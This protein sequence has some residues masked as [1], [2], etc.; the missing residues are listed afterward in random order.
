M[1]PNIVR[2]RDKICE[3]TVINKKAERKNNYGQKK[4]ISVILTFVVASWQRASGW[5]PPPS[6]PSHLAPS[7][8]PNAV[9]RKSEQ[10]WV[11]YGNVSE[12]RCMMGMEI[13]VWRLVELDAR[14]IME[15][16]KSGV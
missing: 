4:Q 5:M 12:A 3:Y 8:V 7:L 14:Q 15:M 11:D 10:R 1:L 16:R 2:K 9:N 13:S 6:L